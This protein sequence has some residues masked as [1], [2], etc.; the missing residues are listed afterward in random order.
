MQR[1]ISLLWEIDKRVF[2][3]TSI[4]GQRKVKLT[5][6]YNKIHDKLTRAIRQIRRIQIDE[7]DSLF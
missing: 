2:I 7:S 4:A 1:T 3:K 6:M 5:N